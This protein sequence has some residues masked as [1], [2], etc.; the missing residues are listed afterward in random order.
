MPRSIVDAGADFDVAADAHV[1][2]LGGQ[3]MSA[4]DVR[5]AEAVRADHRAAVND[6]AVADDR[7][8]VEHGAGADQHI[9]TDFA[10]GQDLCTGQNRCAVADQAV[11]ADGDARV[12][13]DIFA[14]PSRRADDRP[15]AD[16]DCHPVALR[17]KV[18]N[19]FRERRVHIGHDNR[20]AGNQR[21]Q[22]PHPQT[23]RSPRPLPRSSIESL[24]PIRSIHSVISPAATSART[25]AP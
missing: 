6:R 4:G 18:G 25:S 3:D 8:F 13:V 14:A 20:R 19:D 5:V 22:P 21:L 2:Q 9:A 15:R 12:N 11:V 10:A 17:P 16:A 23:Y 7:V 24:E 1:T